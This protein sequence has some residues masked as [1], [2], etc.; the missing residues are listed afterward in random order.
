VA[1]PKKQLATELLPTMDSGQLARTLEMTPVRLA[2]LEDTVAQNPGSTIEPASAHVDSI[3]RR[4]VEG[5]G[6]SRAQKIAE[7][8]ALGKTL[9]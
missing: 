9:G 5:L 4:A 6:E 8:L 7:G 2:A 3:G 1:E